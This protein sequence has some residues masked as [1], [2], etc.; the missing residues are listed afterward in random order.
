MSTTWHGHFSSFNAWALSMNP[1]VGLLAQHCSYA[2]KPCI[3]HAKT[4]HE[5]ASALKVKCCLRVNFKSQKKVCCQYWHEQPR[6]TACWL[7][8][9]WDVW[10]F[11]P[12]TGMASEHFFWL[13]GRVATGQR[14]FSVLKRIFKNVG[15]LTIFMTMFTKFLF[16]CCAMLP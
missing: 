6:V 2:D 15:E 8:L 9:Q 13:S 14:A 16:D 4:K 11:I 1:W 3:A 7:Y 5:P 12:A 10:S